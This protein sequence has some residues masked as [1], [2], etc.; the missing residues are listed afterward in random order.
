MNY[1]QLFARTGALERD[2]LSKINNLREYKNDMTILYE[3]PEFPPSYDEAGIR[4]PRYIRFIAHIKNEENYYWL[5]Q[6]SQK[7]IAMH[8]EAVLAKIKVTGKGKYNNPP[9]RYPVF[10]E[11]VL[12]IKISKIQAHK[13]LKVIRDEHI[14]LVSTS[15]KWDNDDILFA[16]KIN[17]MND[18]IT[19]LNKQGIN[20]HITQKPGDHTLYAST[21]DIYEQTKATEIQMRIPTGTQYRALI[22]FKDQTYK[23]RSCGFLLT[24]ESIHITQSDNHKKNTRIENIGKPIEYLNKCS[25]NKTFW[26]KK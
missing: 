21:T 1:E 11:N 26:I 12:S 23:L 10:I 14:P 19:N 22:R 9:R 24:N 5:K 20:A 4:A 7:L 3:D 6:T 8:E 15:S 2:F 13:S 17:M 16:D 25:T 18:F